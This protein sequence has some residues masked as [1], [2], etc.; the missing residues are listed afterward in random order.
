MVPKLC[1]R[2]QTHVKTHDKLSTAGVRYS[3]LYVK[4]G[5]RSVFLGHTDDAHE[6]RAQDTEHTTVLI[7]ES[8]CVL[9]LPVEGG[10][11]PCPYKSHVLAR[12][13]DD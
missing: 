9:P 3:G 12:H 11:K 5:V 6:E 8:P 10:W 7:P 2:G 4:R 1:M 13:H